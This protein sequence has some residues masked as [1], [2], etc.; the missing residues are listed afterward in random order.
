ML[1]TSS[2]EHLLS[3]HRT[4]A[5]ELKNL[6]SDLQQLVYENYSKFI[7]ATDTIRAMKGRVEG[8]MPELHQ[9]KTTM[10]GFYCSHTCM[11][12]QTLTH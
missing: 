7:S 2:L 5:K 3:E 9:L 4:T 1:R 12:Q 10:G 11:C 6:E 8:Q